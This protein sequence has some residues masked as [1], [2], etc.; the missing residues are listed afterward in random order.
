MF[1]D[2]LVNSKFY[3]ANSKVDTYTEELYIYSISK[4][5]ENTLQVHCTRYRKKMSMVVFVYII[6]KLLDK[7]L[8][9]KNTH[10][11]KIK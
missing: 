3:S 1:Q 8:A 4:L 11:Y 5:F 6:Y 10:K 7:E 9:R 2:F